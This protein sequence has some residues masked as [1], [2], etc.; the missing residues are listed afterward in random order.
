MRALQ[1]GILAAAVAG[2]ATL[3]GCESLTPMGPSLVDQHMGEAVHANVV[4]QTENPGASYQ[5]TGIPQIDPD[6]AAVVMD[7]YYKKQSQ[8]APQQMPSIIQIDAN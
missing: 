7:R 5:N 6:T 4:Q 1:L 2:M 8:P 3:I